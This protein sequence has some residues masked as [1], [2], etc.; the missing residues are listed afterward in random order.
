MPTAYLGLA[1]DMGTPSLHKALSNLIKKDFIRKDKG[2]E[3]FI[4]D[5]FLNEWIRMVS[6][7]PTQ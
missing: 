6:N 5:N 2:K 1:Y 7:F 3:Y 4:V